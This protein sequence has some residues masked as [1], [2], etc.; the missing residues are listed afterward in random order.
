MLLS[1]LGKSDRRGVIWSP[2]DEGQLRGTAVVTL[3]VIPEMLNVSSVRP[4]NGWFRSAKK[5]A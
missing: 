1:G 3:A 4:N 2:W 5:R